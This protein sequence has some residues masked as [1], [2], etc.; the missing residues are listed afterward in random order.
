MNASSSM[1]P[2][3][4]TPSVK[5]VEKLSKYKHL[6]IRIGKMWSMETSTIPVVIGALSLI[7]KGLMPG[8]F[9]IHQME[10]NVHAWNRTCLMLFIT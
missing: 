7:N 4:R 1:I 9:K 5:E 10:K 3:G 2:S 8:D 6:G